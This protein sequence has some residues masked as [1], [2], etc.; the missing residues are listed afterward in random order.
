MMPVIKAGITG[1][2]KIWI[3][4]EIWLFQSGNM[5]IRQFQNRFLGE[6]SLGKPSGKFLGKAVGKAVGKVPGES[7]RESSREKPVGPSLGKMP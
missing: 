5:C 4:L 7:R 2:M 3:K 1:I 6:S